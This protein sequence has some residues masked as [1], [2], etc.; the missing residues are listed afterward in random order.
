M[1][2]SSFIGGVGSSPA[3]ARGVQPVGSINPVAVGSAAWTTSASADL[4]PV[5]TEHPTDEA[6][7]SRDIT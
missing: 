3:P 6:G 4:A 7:M 5:T 1:R 2:A